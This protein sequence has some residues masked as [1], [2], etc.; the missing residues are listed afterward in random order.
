MPENYKPN[1]SDPKPSKTRVGSKQSKQVKSSSFL[2]AVF[3][4]TLNKKLL[5]STFD[6]MLHKGE[7]EN[8]SAFIGSTKGKHRNT[9][10][11]YT[12]N[13][14]QQLAPGVV[15]IDKDGNID[16]L[17]TFKDIVK[18]TTNRFDNFNYTGAYAS[19]SKTFLPP[20][21]IDKF[22]NHTF[23]YWVPEVT[24]GTTNDNDVVFEKDYI[25]IEQDGTTAWSTDNHWYHISDTAIEYQTTNRQAKRPI[26]EFDK[27]LELVSGIVKNTTNQT[28]LFVLYD[29]DGIALDDTTKY[30]APDFTGSKLIGY[31]EKDV[32]VDPVLGLPIAYSDNAFGGNI[33]FE[34][35]LETVQYHYVDSDENIVEITGQYYYKND[36]NITTHYQYNNSHELTSDS[37]QI[38]IDDLSTDIQFNV[39][40]SSWRNQKEHYLIT[41]NDKRQLVE[42]NKDTGHYTFVD[43]F[44]TG[45]LLEVN[46]THTI[47]NF[48]SG[49]ELRV[50]R[51]DGDYNNPI[52]D[53]DGTFNVPSDI[54]T[55]SFGFIDEVIGTVFIQ[56]SQE[57]DEANH[58]LYLNGNKVEPTNYYID[59]NITINPEILQIGDVL[60]LEYQNSIGYDVTDIPEILTSNTTGTILSEFTIADTISHWD[61]LLEGTYQGT[62]ISGG[63]IRIFD[64]SMLYNVISESYDYLNVHQSL[65][66]Q[67]TDW[68]SFKNRFIG[69]V[70]RNWKLTANTAIEEL[71]DNVLRDLTLIKEGIELY[72]TEN[73]V[74]G[75]KYIPQSLASIGITNL[76]SPCRDNDSIICHDGD[77]YN[78]A[79]SANIDDIT[80]PSYDVVGAALM[81]LES[82]IYNNINTSS[83][84]DV[85]VYL[86]SLYNSTWYSIT[87]VNDYMYQN[88]AAGR[89]VNEITN[90]GN[91]DVSDTDGWTWNYSSLEVN[92]TKIPGHWS[93]I[94]NMLFGTD[95]PHLAPWHMLGF[96]T[97]PIVP[98]TSMT[99]GTEY[100]IVTIGNTNWSA[101]GC[102]TCDF[103]TTNDSL[104]ETFIYNGTPVEGDGTVAWWDNYYSWTDTAKRSALI[105]SLARGITS[106]PGE[107]ETINLLYARDWDFTNNA[108]V[109][110]QGNLV[111]PK[112]ILS[113]YGSDDMDSERFD[114]FKFGDCGP[115]ETLWRKSA[116]GQASLINVITKFIP[117]TVCNQLE[118]GILETQQ[119]FILRN[120]YNID[121]SQIRDTV[122]TRLIHCM[123][124]FSGSD[125]IK[126]YSES[127]ASGEYRLSTND[128]NIHMAKGTPNELLTASAVTIIKQ[129]NGY[130]IFGQS[131]N[132]QQFEFNEQ[133][134]TVGSKYDT[135]E[136]GNASVREYAKFYSQ[137]SLLEFGSVLAK[138]QDVYNFL[139]GYVYRLN[140]VGFS[141]DNLNKNY[142]REFIKWMST[143]DTNHKL[144]LSLGQQ[145]TYS[146]QHGSIVEF[147]TLPN[148][149]NGIYDT[150]GNNIPAS[151][152]DISRLD[153]NIQITS[154]D[155]IGSI[156]AATVD[157]QHAIVFDNFTMFND[158]IHNDITGIRHQRF[159]IIG[160]K[161][162]GWDGRQHAPGFLIFGD[163]IIQNF[164][165][166]VSSISDFYDLSVGKFKNSTA[167]SENYSTGET[168]TDWR[169]SQHVSNN[170]L[171][172]FHKGMIK[173]KGTEHAI[174][175]LDRSGLLLGL[176]NST[177]SVNES[178]MFRQGKLG[179]DDTDRTEIELRQHEIKNKH[180]ILYLNPT[181]TKSDYSTVIDI[182]K[183]DILNNDKRYVNYINDLKFDT[184]TFG[185]GDSNLKLYTAGDVLEGE[186]TETIFNLENIGN[187]FDSTSEYATIPTWDNTIS[188]KK[189]DDVRHQGK[190]YR[191]SVS[192]TGLDLIADE[193]VELGNNRN[194]TFAYGTTAQLSTCDITDPNCDITTVI[195]GNS[196]TSHYD[197]NITGSAFDPITTTQTS[198]IVIDNHYI[199][200]SAVGFENVFADNPSFESTY[201]LSFA[202]AKD[203]TLIIDSITYD[204]F[205]SA[206]LPNE[207]IVSD[208]VQTAFTLS[209]E[210]GLDT[211]NI[212]VSIAKIE[213]D[214]IEIASSQYSVDTQLDAVEFITSP[215][216]T[217][218]IVVFFSYI[219]PMA[220]QEIIDRIYEQNPPSTLTFSLNSGGMLK[221]IKDVGGDVSGFITIGE[222]TANTD[223]GISPNIIFAT[224]QSAPTYTVT[225]LDTIIS[226][227]E[228]ENIS[229]ISVTNVDNAI[230][231]ISTN[232]SLS[233][234]GSSDILTSLGLVAS[235]HA[236]STYIEQTSDTL[237]SAI[238]K[239]RLAYDPEDINVIEFTNVSGFLEIKTTLPFI[240]LGDTEFNT[241]AGIMTGILSTLNS[242]IVNIFK[243]DEW[244]EK[245]KDPA[246]ISVHTVDDTSFMYNSLEERQVRY[247]GWNV[248]Q[249]MSFGLYSDGNNNCTICAGNA[250]ADGNDAQI[251]FN[252]EHNLRIGDY[253]LILNSTTTPS[254][255]GIHKVTQIHNTDNTTLYVDSF[256]EK[257]GTSPG[258]LVARS[259]RFKK[260]EELEDSPS[261]IYYNYQAGDLAWC[262]EFDNNTG[263]SVRKFN[264]S[265]TFSKVRKTLFRP[266]NIDLDA[267]QIYNGDSKDQSFELE[268]FDPLRGII[269][270]VAD[271]NI[272]IISI[273]DFAAYTDSDDDTDIATYNAWGENEV[274][275][276]WWDTS[277]VR[278]YDYDQGD[279]DY[280]S[281]HWAKQFPG[282]S[283][284]VYEWTKSTVPPEE[285]AQ[286]VESNTAVYGQ[287]A[288]GVVYTVSQNVTDDPYYY[289][290]QLTQWNNRL[291]QYE[292]IYYFWVKNKTAISTKEKD[293]TVS[294]IAKMINDPTA[295][296]IGWCAFV[297]SYSIILSNVRPYLNDDNSILQIDTHKP[298]H[299]HTN[300][301]NI[302]AGIDLIPDYWY[303][304][305]RDNLVGSTNKIVETSS[306]GAGQMIDGIEYSIV[307]TGT[308]GIPT[309]FTLF[310]ASD[311]EIGT[312][313]VY[314]GVTPVTGDGILYR[315]ELVYT[316]PLPN[317]LIH[318]FNQYG[319]DRTTGQAWFV[320]LIAAR[321]E[322]IISL[323]YI[324][325][326]INLLNTTPTWNNRLS[327]Y[328]TLNAGPIPITDYW[329]YADYETNEFNINGQSPSLYLDSDT[330][331]STVDSSKDTLVVISKESEELGLPQDETYLYYNG[332]WHMIKKLNS[333]IQFNALVYDIDGW[334]TTKWDS[335]TWNELHQDA[336][337]HIAEAVRHDILINAS[338]KYFNTWFFNIIDYVLSDS[339]K[340]DW[341]Y[342]TTY[343]DISIETPLSTGVKKYKR[344]VVE[345]LDEYITEVKPYH[346]KVRQYY[347][348]NN[349]TEELTTSISEMV[350]LDTD[351][352]FGNFVNEMSWSNDATFSGEELSGATFNDSESYDIIEGADFADDNDYEEY[353]CGIFSHTHNYMNDSYGNT[354]RMSFNANIQ[355]HLAL[356]IIT[357][358]SGATVDNDSR[359]YIYL[360][361]THSNVTAYNLTENNQ[362]LLTTDVDDSTMSIGIT[363]IS[364]FNNNGGYAIIGNEIFYY[365]QIINNNL[366]HITRG[367]KGTYNRSAIIGDTIISLTDE[368]ISTLE[369]IV[370][371]STNCGSYISGLRFNDPGKSLLDIGQ[372]NMEPEQIQNSTKGISF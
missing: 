67:A 267:I 279:L 286:L 123:Y 216:T 135:I 83:N 113:A 275:K 86:P 318:R 50:W 119:N 128:Y 108:P 232:T 71:V 250:T 337:Y 73:M 217:E 197:I 339:D 180:Q 257:C 57:I 181:A 190:L 19:N 14:I 167:M 295:V 263:T 268:V 104:G 254:I 281:T 97:E 271:R 362:S 142:A 233:I 240:D 262:S 115:V 92:N 2:P 340:A 210:L 11:V 285:W 307:S 209:Q 255:D 191:C 22:R 235:T 251:T 200:L 280:K 189:H 26:L 203:K 248:L 202:D 316:R 157:Y 66:G 212:D 365:A 75:F 175:Q 208:G 146:P 277:T 244:Y 55:L 136:I 102:S 151:S 8:I 178:W 299:S 344:D 336:M 298:G 335:D 65:L 43:T 28:P 69:Q 228:E 79:P 164:D 259:V 59:N 98:A 296:G 1:G 33:L 192:S 300:W 345:H 260:L 152:L 364:K 265:D 96:P 143:A 37:K 226:K 27:D 184:E 13:D 40:N 103:P 303:L 77:V 173:H 82:R 354:R 51:S 112:V 32:S 158:I 249:F 62:N 122:E 35:F 154:T 16:N 137:Q 266:T 229:G 132:K 349:V 369:S 6:Q 242:S 206:N 214:G 330:D 163:K 153:G 7:L 367:V 183:D 78:M 182:R 347:K 331:I 270:G 274:G 117:S 346:T 227:I 289:Y 139:R 166:S 356:V 29:E 363:D 124:G 245:P 80:S 118:N 155:K 317:K 159:K 171:S 225:T 358:K 211:N 25:L 161:T 361:D 221:V 283:I 172:K 64:N 56:S 99:S 319:D 36:N 321:R 342:K 264:V 201:I 341:V 314:N 54:Q 204:L 256:I 322:A 231:I 12:S 60:D 332:T 188:Y 284:D 205:N 198:N 343:V 292:D 129:A 150:Y 294:Q 148:N 278:Y 312:T 70:K 39:S 253:I 234:V 326:G 310:G 100:T 144:T 48:I 126:I 149:K 243:D 348:N 94:Y 87:D 252:K 355:E 186:T 30:N 116:L 107:A 293:L 353:N 351:I 282:S 165:T 106:I 23:Y 297:D 306:I 134:T 305:A 156:T 47:H 193:I 84:K 224:A 58:T 230:N 160:Q 114:S 45:I 288:A 130:Q 20:I 194:P 21:N 290:T 236:A 76:Y 125:L 222:G 247:G 223:L 91:P 131:P 34:N 276:I 215:L 269:P 313:F 371:S 147:N 72:A 31:K 323:N 261:S 9:N 10:D 49:T 68:L 219:N 315:I 105:L 90:L 176:D 89:P 74:S 196:I 140:S 333:T 110:T 169:S 44:P 138:A 328:I 218:T 174:T 338:E 168:I 109:D 4:T 170:T 93:G 360:Q 145:I 287:I 372:N 63:D 81:E 5:D 95:T 311:N 187:V 179:I 101:I 17:I 258:I 213:I 237:D 309:D 370:E 141:A 85:T 368:Q 325:V 327:N 41:D 133:H 329:D 357:N 162:N 195:F 3:N 207:T 320:D 52:S 308:A 304:G 185:Y 121:I 18:K 272:D 53:I 359:T 273:V 366:E 334:D 88:F 324:L 220:G 239:L 246:R 302:T 238:N 352:E 291:G 24:G 15:A 61:S 301:T 177:I 38:I 42:L 241:S 127:G 111:S 46:V 199:G 120:R 350:K